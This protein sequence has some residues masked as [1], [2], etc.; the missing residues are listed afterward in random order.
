[1]L[2]L[3]GGAAGLAVAYALSHVILLLAF[4]HARNMPLHASPS[5]TV[6]GF[7]FLVSLLTGISFG[8]IP[9]WLSS[10]GQRQMESFRTAN[11]ST[12]D[13]TSVAQRTL[14]ITQTALSVVLV[15][16]AFMMSRSLANLEHQNFG[17]TTADRYI[18]RI[19]P[20]GA[21]YTLERLPA[22]YRLIEDRLTALPAASRVS[23][24]RY[25]PLSGNSWGTCIV[26]QGH[27]APGPSDNCMSSWA[28][29]SYRFLA[30]IGVP[31]VRGRD[32]SAQDTQN[33]TP[34]AIVNQA[35]AQQYF[36]HQDPIG[37]HFG[38]ETPKNSGAFEIV[39][40]FADFKMNDP[41]QDAGPLFLRP[42]SQQ[43]LGYTDPEAISSEKHSMFVG[44]IIIQFSRPQ[45]DAENLLRH[46]MAEVDPNL[47]I[48]YF[49]SYDSQIAAN[50]NQD[51]LVAR[52]TSLFGA[53]ALTLASVGLYGVI[54][55]FVTRRTTEIGIRMA[56]GASRNSILYMVMRGAFWPIL[57]G[58]V[59]GVPA[60]LYICHLSANLLYGVKANNPVVYL[61]SIAAL[62]AAAAVAGFIPARRAASIDPMQA[63]RNE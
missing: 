19:E 32:I 63:L 57:I 26:Q 18:L 1:M 24:A 47:T 29:V 27:P 42:L 22:L 8:T 14:V 45:S 12:G 16:G 13:R 11:R 30:T 43:Y 7:A 39:G 34:V 10:P 52:L 2:S 17:I 23:F 21:G 48:F 36:P 15:S 33:S 38:I 31:I 4:P 28:R 6:L 55:F 60:A 46:A 3:L 25:T 41:R 51:R 44:S 9:A 59:L 53:L 62:G 35:F 61:A 5:L 56:M 50:F 40:V 49:S 54:S 58:V 37:K 20:D